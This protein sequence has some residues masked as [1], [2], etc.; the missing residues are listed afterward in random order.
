M[1]FDYE[2]RP[3]SSRFVDVIWRTYDTSDGTYLAAADA[4]LCLRWPTAL[5]S[6]ASWL[7]CLAAARPTVISDLAHLVDI[8]TLD[9]RGGPSHSSAEPVALRID[10]LDEEASLQLAMRALVDDA[11]LRETLA[12]AGHAYWSANHTVDVMAADYLR[13]IAEAANRPAPAVRDLP[14]H[15]TADHSTLARGITARFGLALDT[16]LGAG[17]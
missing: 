13:V 2:E 6:S 12:R 7:Q 17:S 14:P 5:E 4:C 3:S 15:F 11:R 9:P 8:P 1:S 10:L 16:V